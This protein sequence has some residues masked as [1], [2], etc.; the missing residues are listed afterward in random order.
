MANR[1]EFGISN[2]HIMTYSVGT[3]GTVTLGTPYHLPG[4]VS[5]SL[6]ETSERTDFYADNQR[7]YVTY[8]S[9]TFDGDLEVALFPDTF[10]T[11]YLGYFAKSDGGVGT[12]KNA[13]RPNVAMAFQ[14]EGDQNARRVILYNCTFGG[15]TRDYETLEETKDPATESIAISVLGDNANGVSMVSYQYGA[16]GYSTLFTNPPA[17]ATT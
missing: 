2:V 15:M 10:K 1:V 8:T 14:V 17:P 13:T 16:T 12:V 9:G 5:L 7:Y 3:G 6:E 4:A 11:Q